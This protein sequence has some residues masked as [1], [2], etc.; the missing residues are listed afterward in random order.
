MMHLGLSTA[1]TERKKII[2]ICNLKYSSVIKGL[3]M[4]WLLFNKH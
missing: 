1:T 2:L 3:S 4:G